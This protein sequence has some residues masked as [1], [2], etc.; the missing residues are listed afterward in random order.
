M[1]VEC[2][3]GDKWKEEIGGAR[4]PLFMLFEVNTCS[5]CVIFRF[6]SLFYD[7]VR[8]IGLRGGSLKPITWGEILWYKHNIE[9]IS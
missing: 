5:F 7:E 4:M 9:G 6:W 3:K 2:G 8:N 1:V